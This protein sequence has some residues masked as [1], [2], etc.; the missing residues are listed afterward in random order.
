MLLFFF[1]RFQFQ[2][3]N[4]TVVS[5]LETIGGVPF[6]K[7]LPGDVKEVQ[8]DVANF[9]SRLTDMESRLTKS[10]ADLKKQLDSYHNELLSDLEVSSCE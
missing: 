5:L 10:E 9:G 7:T 4:L 1:P 8:K 6:I 3:L 2:D